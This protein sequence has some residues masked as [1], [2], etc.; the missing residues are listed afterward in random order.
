MNAAE[1]T[2]QNRML[3]RPARKERALGMGNDKTEPPGI[4][5]GTFPSFSNLINTVKY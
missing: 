2:D 5:T 1:I 4:K 3:P